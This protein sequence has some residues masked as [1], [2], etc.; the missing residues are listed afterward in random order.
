MELNIFKKNSKNVILISEKGNNSIYRLSR[1]L[2]L[3]H[4]EHK[5]YI[6]GRY[7]VL[8]EVG[9][10]PAYLMGI[11]ILKLRKNLLVHFSST[12]KKFLQDSTTLLAN[13]IQ[14]KKISSLVILNYFPALN[15]F[16][17]WYQ[18][19]ISESLGKS[20]K[21]LLPIISPAPKDHHSLLQLYLDGPKDKLFYIFSSQTE[22]YTKLNP[23]IFGKEYN[24]LKNK[25]FNQIRIAQKNALIRSLKKRDIPLREFFIKDVSEEILGE[26]FS[27]F[28]LETAITG[29]LINI[30][31]FNQPSVEQVKI[32]TKKFLS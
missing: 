22:Q 12:S 27:Y 23:K 4:I 11:N 24:F 15:K 20:G 13:I 1:K 31:P 14:N 10:V 21:G 29:Y 17:I 25:N 9:L 8:S 28:I 7:S 26:L 3:F 16:L 18:Q 6:G 30:N 19:L 2:N 32:D 5:K